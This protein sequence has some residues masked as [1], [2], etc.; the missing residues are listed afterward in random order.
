L[1]D[2][3]LALLLATRPVTQSGSA[4]QAFFYIRCRS[5]SAMQIC[6]QA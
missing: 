3:E 2:T 4:N 5:G 6:R 1:V